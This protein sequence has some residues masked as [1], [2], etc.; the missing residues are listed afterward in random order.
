MLKRGILGPRLIIAIGGIVGIGGCYLSSTITN[1][2]IFRYIFPATYGFMVGFTYMTH[3]YLAWKCIP[4]YEGI[5]T[6]IVNS[7]FACG[8]CIFNFISAFMLNPD[9]IDPKKGKGNLDPFP[10]EIADNLPTTL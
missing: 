5:M 9:G 3:L 4:V 10:S 6:G 2:T 7:G 8:G 1:W